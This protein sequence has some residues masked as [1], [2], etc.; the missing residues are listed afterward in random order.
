VSRVGRVLAEGGDWGGRGK[1]RIFK[2][3]AEARGLDH[4]SGKVDLGPYS[5]GLV[6]QHER[7]KKASA[8][9]RCPTDRTACSCIMHFHTHLILRGVGRGARSRTCLVASRAGWLS[10]FPNK[11][12]VACP[13]PPDGVAARN[14]GTLAKGIAEA[15]VTHGL[16]RRSRSK[17]ARAGLAGSYQR[18]T[19]SR[20]KT[21]GLCLA[22][23]CFLVL[24]SV[25]C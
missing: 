15:A 23:D 16:L 8:A 6:V 18:A 10:L 13:T 14:E 24:G 19:A 21:T 9:E 25:C 12:A 11:L 5:G 2:R 3:A 7:V 1:G 17:H 4:Q 22:E 20:S